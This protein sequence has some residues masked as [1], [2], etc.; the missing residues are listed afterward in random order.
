MF[1]FLLDLS[2]FVQRCYG[3]T[4][5]IISQMASLYHNQQRT[6]NSFKSVH[7]QSVFES[8]M[9]LFGVLI[10]LDEIIQANVSFQ[11][12]IALYK[13]MVKA[14]KSDPSRYNADEERLWQV[15]KLLYSIKGQLLDGRIFQNCIE[16]EFDTPGVLD[17]SNNKDLKKEMLFNVKAIFT[18]LNQRIGDQTEINQ[19]YSFVGFSGLY[20]FYITLFK[21][22]SDSKFFKSVWELHKKLP[23]VHIFGDITWSLNDFYSKTVPMML[24]LIK[25]SD[26]TPFKRDYLKKLDTEFSSKVQNFYLQVCIWMVRM[27]SN[28]TNRADIQN[29]LNTRIVLLSQGVTLA[30]SVSNLFKEVVSL[31][32]LLSTPL[33]SKDVKHLSQ[34]IELLK[35]IQATFH[36]RSSMI[37]ETISLMI[38]QIQSYLNKYLIPIQNKLESS[39]VYNKKSDSKLDC[40]AAVTLALQ[41]LNNTPTIQRRTIV[42]LALHL[43]QQSEFLREEEIEEFN[44]QF[45]KLELLAELEQHI[46]DSCNTSYLYWSRSMLPNYFMDVYSHPYESQKLPYMFAGLRDIIPLFKKMVHDNPT[47]YIDSYIKEIDTRL[48][49]FILDPLCRDIETDLRLHIHAH[50]AIS[51]RNPWKNGVKDLSRFFKIRPIR[52][53][54]KSIDIKRYVSHYLDTTFYNL[55]TI[56]L[57]DWKTYGEMRNLAQ[58]KYGLNLTEVHLPSQT[59]EQ[60]IDVLQIMRNIHIFVARYNYNIHNQI[61]IERTSDSKTLNTITINHISNSIRTH[62][63]GIMNTT[64]STNIFD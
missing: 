1:H 53:Y 55:T 47:K 10:S 12:Y 24:K 57:H 6:L 25:N 43:L 30:Y 60:G 52:F 56:A 28:L 59:L 40:L 13:R 50:L 32:L 41:M 38:Q 23:L 29:I 42:K 27:E 20:V 48:K 39:G 19:R 36:R 4:K 37:G 5:N 63:I 3:V 16:Q 18:A 34:C 21:D 26:L 2:K 9:S 31:H 58:E 46:L 14:I 45:E 8:L 51:D 54:D 7:L 11:N 49:T 61:F 35:S 33:K 62:G 64:V 44:K 17:V 22:T 15:E